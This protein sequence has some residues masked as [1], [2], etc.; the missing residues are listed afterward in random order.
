MSQ[1]LLKSQKTGLVEEQKMF[2]RI[3]VA[4]DGS[5]HADKALD[6]ALDLAEKYYAEIVLLSVIPSAIVPMGSY[7]NMSM[8]PFS[9]VIIDT[10]LKEL[11][12]YHE[13]VLSHALKKAKKTKPSLEV[14]TKLAEG[15]PSDRIVETVKEGN[16]DLIVM[17]SRG[18]GGISEFFLGS[19]SHRVVNHVPCPVLIVK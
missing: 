8:E 10:Y 11:K 19:V 17:G 2:K 9:P 13:R 14:S 12:S 6:F 7:P 3:L 18:L 5:E 16:F 15:R 1:I 4:L